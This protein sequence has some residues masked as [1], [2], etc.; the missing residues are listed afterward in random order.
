MP[1]LLDA[2]RVAWTH[3]KVQ[4]ANLVGWTGASGHP[5]FADLVRGVARH[6]GERVR[7]ED[8]ELA[9]WETA[10]RARTA[11]AYRDFLAA[12]PASRFAGSARARASSAKPTSRRPHR[13]SPRAW[14]MALATDCT[15]RVIQASRSRRD[16]PANWLKSY[17]CLV[18]IA[19][20]G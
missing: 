4:Y 11:G 10:E 19:R 18:C 13:P 7:P 14:S 2:G 3:Q 1:V 20:E 15:L 6:A 12:H 5:G 8:V 16:R 17:Q 9:A